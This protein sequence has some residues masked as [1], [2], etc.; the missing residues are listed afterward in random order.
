V[1]GPSE[2]ADRYGGTAVATRWP[3]RVVAVDEHRDDG[4]HWWT[5]AVLV[6]DVLFVVPTTPWQ[7]AAA[8][9]RDRQAAAVVELADRH[10]GPVVVAGDLNALPGD[11]GVRRLAA[12]F[13]DAG[14]LAGATWTAENPLAAVEIART[15]CRPGRLDYVFAAGLAVRAARLVCDRPV[16]GVWL[17]DHAAVLAELG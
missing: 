11:G 9:V 10:Q 15:G 12:R 5:L 3:H 6:R 4:F 8:E 13:T 2:E 1:L 14:A 16:D 7:P 17:S